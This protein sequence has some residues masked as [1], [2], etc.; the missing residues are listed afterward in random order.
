MNPRL[1]RQRL[2]VGSIDLLEQLSARSAELAKH[3]ALIQISK[4][5]GNG[6]IELGQTVK[7]AIAQTAQHPALDDPDTGLNLRLVLGPPR[8][9]RQHRRSI[10]PRH[11]RVAAVEHRIEVASLDHRDLGIVGHQQLRRSAEE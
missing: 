2:Q 4:A 1:G 3:A 7:D 5:I 6:S 8:P 11:V 9:R 10:M